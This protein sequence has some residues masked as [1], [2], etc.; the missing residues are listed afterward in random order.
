MAYR[1]LELPIETIHLA[2]GT[3]RAAIKAEETP[4]EILRMIPGFIEKR[5]AVHSH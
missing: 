4:I 3:E 2:D 1:S 5:D